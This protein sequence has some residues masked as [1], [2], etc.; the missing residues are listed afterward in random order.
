V[1]SNPHIGH[2]FEFILAD[3]LTK[4]YKQNGNK[5]YFNTGIDEHGIKVYSKSVE[6]GISIQEHLDNLNDI[7]IDFCKKFNIEYDN[8][9]R[10][11]T[12]EHHEKVKVI[13]TKFLERGD[14][15]KKDYIGK[16]CVGCESFKV[17][18][19]IVNNK[20]IDHTNLKLQDVNEENYFFKLTKYKDVLLNWIESNPD[21]LEPKSKIDELKNLITSSEDIS[22]SRLKENCPWGVDVPGDDKHVIY[23]WFDALLNYIFAAGYLTDNFNWDNVI[24][25]CGP[26][27]LRFQAVIFQSFLESEGIKKS[28]K[29]LVHGTI[30]DKDGKKIS[31]SL[32]N[33][34]DPIEQLEKYGVD[35]IKYYSLCGLSTYTNSNWNE[36]DL[37]R[38]WNSDICNDWGNLVSRTLHLIDTRL[39]GVII[40]PDSNFKNDVSQFESNI[41][42]LWDEFKIKEA[43]QRTNELVKFAN[44][45]IN[46][47]K[48]WTIENPIN[49]LSNLYYLINIT[50][51]LYLPVLPDS[52]DI[53]K[54]KKKSIL[55]NKIC[56]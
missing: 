6:L 54:T 31:K 22:I 19:E 11:S 48:P 14:I 56:V 5:V 16:Y 43:L 27:N 7:W 38:I 46:D 18:K 24:Q 45:Y 8:F 39:D 3:S 55:Y 20:C 1:N 25:L 28:S 21:F 17:D 4:Y 34:I 51:K 29:L 40:E 41:K 2:L 15:Y 10:T 36:N 12:I 30:L 33:T 42:S 13:W 35:A 26:D 50:N 44:K 52:Q 47:I 37:I 23:V 49:E 32:G 9:Y 53:I